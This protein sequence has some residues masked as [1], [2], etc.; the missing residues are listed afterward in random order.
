MVKLNGFPSFV[1]KKGGFNFLHA[2]PPLGHPPLTPNSIGFTRGKV[3]P[4]ATPTPVKPRPRSGLARPGPV[5]SFP[6]V[7]PTVRLSISHTETCRCSY[8]HLFLSTSSG[9]QPHSTNHSGEHP[10][11]PKLAL[12]PIP[13]IQRK[14]LKVGKKQE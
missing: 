7:A 3:K 6:T 10:G 11:V 5:N 12:H 14:E 13:K 9:P 1:G 4:D 8:H 2:N